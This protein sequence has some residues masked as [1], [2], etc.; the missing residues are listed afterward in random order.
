MKTIHWITLIAVLVMTLVAQI[1]TDPYYW[2]ERILGFFA[3]FGFVGCL[4]LMFVAKLLGH[5]MVSHKPD[6]YKEETDV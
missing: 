1:L 2:W 3:I 6:Y 4:L 5:V